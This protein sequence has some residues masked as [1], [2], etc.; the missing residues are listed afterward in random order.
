MSL[1]EKIS[2]VTEK[3]N[4][5]K[6]SKNLEKVIED[7]EIVEKDIRDIGDYIEEL[8][9]KLVT[10]NNENLNESTELNSTKFYN[11]CFD[12]IK[13]INDT[14][15]NSTDVDIDIEEQIAQYH[16]MDNLIGLLLKYLETKKMETFN[17]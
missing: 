8:K 11:D 16:E 6:K 5:L 1:E 4:T 3:V 14:I 12:K 13:K 15:F 9:K 17:V 10:P 2:I 7:R